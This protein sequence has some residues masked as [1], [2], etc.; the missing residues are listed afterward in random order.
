MRKRRQKKPKEL[1]RKRI[2]NEECWAWKTVPKLHRQQFQMTSIDDDNYRD[3]AKTTRAT[4][5]VLKASEKQ[6]KSKGKA[7]ANE[8]KS[9]QNSSSSLTASI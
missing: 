3:E 6:V 2:N 1:G 5:T 9:I 7:V 4:P 8:A